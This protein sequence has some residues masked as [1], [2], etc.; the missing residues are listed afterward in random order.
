[1]STLVSINFKILERYFVQYKDIYDTCS[2]NSLAISNGDN[3]NS[4]KL[5]SRAIS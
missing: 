2:V 5:A 4:V 3:C 1:M